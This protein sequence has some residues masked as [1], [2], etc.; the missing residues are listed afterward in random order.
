[1]PAENDLIARLPLRARNR[2]LAQCERVTLSLSDILHEAGSAARW[3]YFPTSGFVSLIALVDESSAIEVGMVGREG[4][5][6]V[7]VTMGIPTWPLRC[8]VQGAGDAWRLS[9]SKFTNELAHSPTLQ[10]SMQRYTAVLMSQLAS[11]AACAR[12]HNIGPRLARWLLMSQDRAGTDSFRVT[13]EFLSYMLG[14]R[15]VGITTAAVLLQRQGLIAYHRGEVSIV[16]RG[17]L[18]DAACSCYTSDRSIYRLLGVRR[19]PTRA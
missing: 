10:R 12:Y 17:G 13:H 5:V 6:G 19:M 4:M 1:L 8:V 14:V 16:D 2:F 3:V 18:E 11:S 7:Q 9:A 15:R